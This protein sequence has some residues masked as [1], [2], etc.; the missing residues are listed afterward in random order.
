MRSGFGAIYPKAVHDG[1]MARAEMDTILCLEGKIMIRWSRSGSVPVEQVRSGFGGAGPV[2]FRWRR[3]G[4][5][6]MEQDRS[7][8]GVGPGKI[9]RENPGENPWPLSVRRE[10]WENIFLVCNVTLLISTCF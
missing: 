1:A 2:R 6:P 10:K 5:V 7:S 3:S 9:P 4:P 8:S